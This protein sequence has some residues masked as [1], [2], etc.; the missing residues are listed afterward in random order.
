M[1]H[2]Y[3]RTHNTFVAGKRAPSPENAVQGEWIVNRFG[4]AALSGFEV[5]GRTVILDETVE[6]PVL[7]LAGAMVTAASGY[8]HPDGTFMRTGT[9][10]YP[11][12]VSG[13]Y[14]GPDSELD[15]SY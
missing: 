2:T 9:Y 13:I 6:P 10:A 3:T 12:E 4:T 7:R 8:V 14:T 15:L 1:A 11:A 5:D